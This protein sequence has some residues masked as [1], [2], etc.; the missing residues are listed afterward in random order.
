MTWPAVVVRLPFRSSRVIWRVRISTS[1]ARVPVRIWQRC[2]RLFTSRTI[3]SKLLSVPRCFSW[4]CCM[5]KSYWR[6]SFFSSLL[7]VYRS[8]V[9][10]WETRMRSACSIYSSTTSL[11]RKSVSQPPYSVLMTYLPSEKAPAPPIPSIMA[12][13][14]HRTHRLVCPA[15]MGHL[16]CSRGLPC[17]TRQTWREGSFSVRRWAAISPPMPPPMM[18]TS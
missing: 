18:S 5:C 17:S 12:Q 8:V 10:P 4:A 13:L 9:A 1:V 16:R 15:T 11:G 14:L 6:Q 7:G 3:V 2:S